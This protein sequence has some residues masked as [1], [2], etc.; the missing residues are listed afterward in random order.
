MELKNEIWKDIDG[1][2]GIYQVSTTGRVKHLNY[3]GRN[4][5]KFLTPQRQRNGYFTVVLYNGGIYKTVS[6]HRLVAQAF[7][8]ND[9]PINKTQVN[10]INEDKSDNRAENLNWM[11]PKENSNWGTHKQRVGLANRGKTISEEQKAK[12]SLKMKGK[13]H[14]QSEETR[15]KISLARKKYWALKKRI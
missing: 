12:Q 7:I 14:P 13:S 2:E 6:I 11:T 8:T 3:R 15:M 5:D 10:H 1:F 4:V 9:D